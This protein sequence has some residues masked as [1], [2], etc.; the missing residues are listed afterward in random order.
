MESLKI[1]PEVVD[2]DDVEMLED[3]VTA[4]VNEALTQVQG[5]QMGQLAGL[6]GGSSDRALGGMPGL[7]GARRCS[8]AA[9]QARS[10]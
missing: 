4:A 8:R 9:T 10:R 5:F 1:E 6:T 3:L 7:G 2:P